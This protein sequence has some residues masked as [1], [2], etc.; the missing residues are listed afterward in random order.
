VGIESEHWI[1]FPVCGETTGIQAYLD[2]CVPSANETFSLSETD[3]YRL[4]CHALVHRLPQAAFGEAV[5]SLS[6]MYDFYQ[7][8]PILPT[9]CP[10]DSMKARITGSCTAPI[11]P[12][13]ED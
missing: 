12:V 2:V 4:M 10:P 11:F 13:L 1:R 6:R 7:D 5:E 3:V 8:L 9:S